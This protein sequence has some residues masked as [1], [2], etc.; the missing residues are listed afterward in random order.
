MTDGSVP[1]F[2]DHC[3][4]CVL[5]FIWIIG[6]WFVIKLGENL[7]TPLTFISISFE[8]KKIMYNNTER[9]LTVYVRN[10]VL[11]SKEI[12]ARRPTKFGREISEVMHLEIKFWFFVLIVFY[13][14]FIRLLEFFIRFMEVF[15]HQ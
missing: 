3:W 14:I 13:F 5:F 2:Y 11:C 8:L 1:F 12:T 10:C 7:I 4:R 6:N 15:L 9:S